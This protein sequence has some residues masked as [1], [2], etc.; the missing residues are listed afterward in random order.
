MS[1]SK[2]FSRGEDRNTPNLNKE[3]LYYDEVK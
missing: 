3:S 2:N 1:R